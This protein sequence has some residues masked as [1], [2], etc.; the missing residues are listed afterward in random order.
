MSTKYLAPKYEKLLGISISCNKNVTHSGSCKY[1]PFCI[2]LYNCN[3][4]RS[5]VFKNV[6][7]LCLLRTWNI[8][9]FM[10][11]LQ[12]AKWACYDSIQNKAKMHLVWTCFH[13]LYIKKK[14]LNIYVIC[15][16]NTASFLF[17]LRFFFF[18]NQYSF[19]LSYISFAI[20]H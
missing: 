17:I 6:E 3:L 4:R 15:F 2:V 18:L 20:M 16:R 1:I 12:R 7:I 13:I 10:T 19:Y 9:M 11:W 5:G 8:A 14:C